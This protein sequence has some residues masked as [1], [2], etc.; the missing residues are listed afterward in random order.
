MMNFLKKIFNTQRKIVKV[1]DYNNYDEYINHQKKKTTDPVRREKWL[2]EEWDL[3]LNYFQKRFEE[4]QKEFFKPEFKKA[5]GL[6]ARTGQE[7]QA[8]L[9]LGYDSIGLDIVPCEPLVIEGDIHNM[10][11]K[12]EEFDIA[13]TNIFDHSLYPE[14]FALEI[15]RILKKDGIAI[16]HLAVGTDTD[17]FG[18]IEIEDSSAIVELFSDM[19]ILKSQKMSEW[20]GGL[21]WELILLKN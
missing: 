16:I 1:Q 10:P 20:G 2:N 15:Q 17:P 7:V 11:F 13:F 19:T 12:D 6:G 5:V 3:K 8:F 21:N 18:V 9:N 14:K 4:Y